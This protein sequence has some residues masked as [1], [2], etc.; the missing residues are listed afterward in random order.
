MNP[1]LSQLLKDC[2]AA[3]GALGGG[4]RLPDRSHQ[5]CSYHASC[6]AETLEKMML[7]LAHTLALLSSH[8]FATRRLGWAFSEGRILVA[9]RPDGAV[10]SLVMKNDAAATDFFDRIASQFYSA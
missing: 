3:P 9:I 7:H 1:A 6:P 5:V 10:F 2:A 8:D 4:I